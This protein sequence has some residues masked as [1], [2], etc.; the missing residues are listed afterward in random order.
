VRWFVTPGGDSLV[1]WATADTSVRTPERV[2]LGHA[3][4]FYLLSAGQVVNSWSTIESSFDVYSTTSVYVIQGDALVCYY[5]E[6][7]F[8]PE[9][10][11]SCTRR[12]ELGGLRPMLPDAI[13]D[14]ARVQSEIVRY[15]QTR[16]EA[17]AAELARTQQARRE[18]EASFE[19]A[20]PRLRARQRITLVWRYVGGD[21]VISRSTGEEVWR[22]SDWPWLG[23]DLYRLLRGVAESKYGI[24]MVDFMVDIPDY[25]AYMRFDPD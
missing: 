13:P 20:L 21:I 6:E 16:R 25:E 4:T 17:Y 2:A 23:R 9:E 7:G 10:H 11:W 14:K 8:G 19:R 12:I 1:E 5:E 24:R 15:Q 22:D 18:R 3:G